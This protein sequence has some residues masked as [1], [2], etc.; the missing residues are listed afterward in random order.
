L[1]IIG[2]PSAW[3]VSKGVKFKV[4]PSKL[5]MICDKSGFGCDG[6]GGDAHAESTTAE[7]IARTPSADADLMVDLSRRAVC[8]ELRRAGRA[9][10]KP[11]AEPF[12][13]L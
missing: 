3:P 11:D 7:Q 1:T 5:G 12:Q 2:W 9:V 6:G 8:H 4:F 13:L 10:Q